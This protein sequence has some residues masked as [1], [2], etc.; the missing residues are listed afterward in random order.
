MVDVY[1]KVY[2]KVYKYK[3]M[4]VCIDWYMFLEN[5]LY[6]VENIYELFFFC[7]FC[8]LNFKEIVINR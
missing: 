2:I 1:N 3:K 6:G 7:V 5:L 8:F 4:Y